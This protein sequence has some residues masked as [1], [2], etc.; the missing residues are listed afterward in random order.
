MGPLQ[1]HNQLKEMKYC[2]D[3]DAKSCVDQIIC[4]KTWLLLSFTWGWYIKCNTVKEK[5]WERF[6]N[7]QSPLQTKNC[8]WQDKKSAGTSR[9]GRWALPELSF[10][11]STIILNYLSELG[12]GVMN[13][14][15]DDNKAT[16]IQ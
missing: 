14:V 10:M 2:S 4:K 7:N 15:D 5:L 3:H 12:R 6:N 16:S 11:T 1:L 9:E 8:M 13:M